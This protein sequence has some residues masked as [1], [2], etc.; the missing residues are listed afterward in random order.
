MPYQMPG[1]PFDPL[2]DLLAP[3]RKAGVLMIIIG[4]IGLVC[5]LCFGGLGFGWDEFVSNANPDDLANLMQIEA[6]FGITAK[7]MLMVV[8]GGCLVVGLLYLVFGIVARGGGAFGI[9]ASM[10]LA[11]LMGLY[12]AINAIALLATGGGG[13][14]LQLV[15]GA[16]FTVFGLGA[17]ILLVTWLVQAAR[18]IGR[19]RELREYQRNLYTR[20]VQQYSAY[21]QYYQRQNWPGY[22]Q[23]PSQQSPPPGNWPPQPPQA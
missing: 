17:T 9:Y 1:Q 16:C 6:Q 13:N 12:V 18:N 7:V 10:A 4:S 8:G 20:H 15:V 5:G 2:A 21:Q 19:I 3:A 14:P 22:G 23:R 11:I